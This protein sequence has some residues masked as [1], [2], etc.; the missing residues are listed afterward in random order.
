MSKQIQEDLTELTKKVSHMG[1][2]VE[3]ALDRSLTALLDR[4]A[5]LAR[6]VIDG[7][8]VV[9]ELENEVEERC[10]DVLALQQP[11]ARDLRYVAG[12][13]KI[14]SDLERMADLAV[15]I[16]ERAEVLASVPPLPFRPDVTRLAALAKRMVRDGLDALQKLDAE[17]AFQTWKADD[18]A[19]RLYREL[20]GE[21]IQFMREHTERIG[22]VMHLVGA[23]RN[24]ERLADHATN[25]AEDVIFVVNGRI[26][27][28]HMR[29][30]DE[31][32]GPGRP[33]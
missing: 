12:I 31:K 3:E 11:V 5:D 26:V 32:G 21:A 2:L 4:D 16:A 33:E 10:L 24:L 22:D 20:I 7:D 8:K 13:L 23:L 30:L 25:I 9:D 1:G 27:R 17:L 29:Q 18:E 6:E 28:H 14:N 19:D 15:N